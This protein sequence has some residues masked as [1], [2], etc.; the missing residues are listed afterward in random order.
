[1]RADYLKMKKIFFFC[2]GCKKFCSCFPLAMVKKKK[3]IILCIGTHKCW[4]TVRGVNN[5][6]TSRSSTVRN[7]YKLRQKLSECWSSFVLANFRV[8]KE[9]EEYFKNDVGCQSKPSRLFVTERQRSTT[10]ETGSCQASPAAQ[11]GKMDQ[12]SHASSATKHFGS[13]SETP[14]PPAPVRETV[15]W[16]SLM[17]QWYR[18]QWF[19]EL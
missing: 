19:K 2:Y 7:I 4:Q 1:M 10:V 9:T 11:V 5:T 12:F 16:Q 18:K 14:G 3:K 15:T 13:H 8:L 17:R 6:T